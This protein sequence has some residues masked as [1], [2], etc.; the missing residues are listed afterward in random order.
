MN[1]QLLSLVLI[2]LCVVCLIVG[3]NPPPGRQSNR[4]NSPQVP[5]PQDPVNDKNFWNISVEAWEAAGFKVLSVTESEQ[6]IKRKNISI[7]TGKF[8]V[9]D[10]H[11]LEPNVFLTIDYNGKFRI[12]TI[13]LDNSLPRPV[14]D[15]YLNEKDS[16]QWLS[17]NGYEVEKTTSELRIKKERPGY[18]FT[19]TIKHSGAINPMHVVGL[20]EGVTLLYQNGNIYISDK[21]RKRRN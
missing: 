16:E 8:S 4:G 7:P 15:G 9:G 6:W 13:G 1:R 14:P 2:G 19:P 18:R 5:T 10:I 21:K 17:N 3:C 12:K 20:P 11:I